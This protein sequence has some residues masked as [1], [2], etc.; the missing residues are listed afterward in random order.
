MNPEN[1]NTQID[2]EDEIQPEISVF[3]N[4]SKIESQ[5]YYL[6]PSSNENLEG[7]IR[8]VTEKFGGNEQDWNQTY[9]ESGTMHFD[10]NSGELKDQ[11]GVSITEMIRNSGSVE[12]INTHE[13]LISA[14]KNG[15]EH[16]QLIEY[17]ETSGDYETFNVTALIMEANGSISSVTWSKESKLNQDLDPDFI[18]D[19]LELQEEIEAINQTSQEESSE[20]ENWFSK[21]YKAD[22]LSYNYSNENSFKQTELPQNSTTTTPPQET[23]IKP[24]EVSHSKNPPPHENNIVVNVDKEITVLENTLPEE[25]TY[26]LE[27]SLTEL[28]KTERSAET[29]YSSENFLEKYDSEKASKHLI[30][31]ENTKP[32]TQEF[33]FP[34]ATEEQNSNIQEVIFESQEIKFETFGITLEESNVNTNPIAEPQNHETFTIEEEIQET[35]TISEDT[36]PYSTQRISQEFGISI[37]NPETTTPTSEIKETNQQPILIEQ[38]IPETFTEKNLFTPKENPTEVVFIDATLP[39]VNTKEVTPIESKEKQVT[40]EIPENITILQKPEKIQLEEKNTLP[41]TP[42][43]EKNNREEAYQQDY[44][45]KVE[46]I[47]LRRISEV[48]PAN[49]ASKQELQNNKNIYELINRIQRVSGANLFNTKVESEEEDLE[50]NTSLK[51]AA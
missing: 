44:T 30:T 20:D 31:T 3:D 42:E 43:L 5:N 35:E 45:K 33:F 50:L 32:N 51:L 15:T 37:S 46:S 14:W 4:G 10:S 47:I 22:L 6:E 26:E 28:A 41:E 39:S 7:T 19:E 2:Y 21:F 34:T 29:K 40:K 1:Q 36:T 9:K 11:S 49:L 25:H 17:S 38:Q 16:A 24:L 27:D 18:F 8:D 48:K 12:Q 23:S 13:Q